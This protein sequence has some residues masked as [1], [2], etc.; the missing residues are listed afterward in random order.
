MAVKYAFI[1]LIESCIDVA[2]HICS[3]DH[4]GAPNSNGD[5]MRRLGA[6]GVISQELAESMSRVVGFRNVLVHAFFVVDD[7]IVLHRLDEHAG[8][9]RFL[10]QVAQWLKTQ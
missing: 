4:L 9:R 8:L 2:Q 10:E 7:E 6:H 1:T 5:A 3:V